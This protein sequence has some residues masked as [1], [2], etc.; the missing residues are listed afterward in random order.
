M[1]DFI[2]AWRLV[3][4]EERQ[5]GGDLTY[6]YGSHPVGLLIYDESGYMSV[7]IMRSDR[8]PLS[9]DNPDETSAEEIKRA[10]EGFTA[11]FGRYEI[12]EQRKTVTHHV[13]GH[14]LPNSVGKR[15]ERSY[16]FSGDNLILKP[17]PARRVVWVKARV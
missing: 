8:R 2:G 12:D 4:V 13:E 10:V 16:E 11:F 5:P 7:Q 1:E 9:S 6:P 17:S 3:A 15:L 14:L